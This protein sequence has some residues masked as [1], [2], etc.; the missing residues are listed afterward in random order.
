[1]FWES[2]DFYGVDLTAL[3]EKALQEKFA[4]PI[5]DTYEPTKKYLSHLTMQLSAAIQDS[6]RLREVLPGRLADDRH[7][8]LAQNRE[9]RL[10]S[11]IRTLLRRDFQGNHS[12]HHIANWAC[13]SSHSLVLDKAVAERTAGSE[14]R[15]DD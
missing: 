4:Q 2:K 9:G 8:L 15:V 11:R 10:D 3:K 6:V 1:M 14:Q 12:I 13:R 5:I 7:L